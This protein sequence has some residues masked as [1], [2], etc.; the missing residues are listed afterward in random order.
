MMLAGAGALAF[1]AA[2][3]TALAH[4]S[5]GMFDL[6]KQVSITGTVREFQWT[7]PHVFI[8]VVA[9]GPGGAPME[10]SVEGTAP[11]VLRRAGWRFDTLKAGE[12]V[13]V[14][15]SPLRDGRPGGLLLHVIGEDGRKHSNRATDSAPSPAA[16]P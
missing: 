7:N 8:E 12:K 6:T 13:T 2:A 10:Y 1:A 5:Y 16:R 15:M 14:S 11:G 4:H 9:Q 3:G